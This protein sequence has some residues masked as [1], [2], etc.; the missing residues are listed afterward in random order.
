MEMSA[1]GRGFLASSSQLQL[2]KCAM[3]DIHG[4]AQVW[5]FLQ[6]RVCL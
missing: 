1:G 5:H 3:N 2:V 6:L 4:D